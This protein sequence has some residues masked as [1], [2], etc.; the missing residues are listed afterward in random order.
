MTIGA[1]KG[2]RRIGNGYTQKITLWKIEAGG[3]GQDDIRTALSE[4]MASVEEL[5]GYKAIQY[6]KAGLESPVIVETV[7]MSQLPDEIIWN[8]RT[9]RVASFVDQD[10]HLKRRVKILGEFKK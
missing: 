10:N 3:Y 7:W 2:S 8:G 9:I 4:Q 5:D 6:R 1:P